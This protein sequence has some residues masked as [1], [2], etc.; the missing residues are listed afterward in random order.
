VTVGAS[1]SSVRIGRDGVGVDAAVAEVSVTDDG[2]RRT[3]DCHGGRAQVT[4]DRN[5]LTFRD[6]IG[7]AVSGDRNEIDAGETET[8]S[9]SG[10]HNRVQYTRG[11]NAPHVSDTGEDNRITPAR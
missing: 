4:G 7:I 10:D 8:L 5:V 3:C 2:V 6:C 11:A 1:G 9:V